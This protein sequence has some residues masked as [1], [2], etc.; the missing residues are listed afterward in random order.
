M[1]KI[2]T[3]LLVLT[4]CVSCTSCSKDEGIGGTGRAGKKLPG[5]LYWFFAGKAGYYNLESGKVEKEWMSMG[6]A[7]SFFDAFDISWD[8]RK[9]LLTMDVEGSFNFDER[10]FVL[11]ENKGKITYKG[12]NDGQNLRDFNYEWGDIKTT[13]GHLS[14][15]EKYVAVEAQ[16]FSDLPLTILDMQT[17]DAISSWMVEGISF[18]RYGK[19]VW[20]ADNTLYFRIGNKLYKCS[21]SNGYRS[22]PKVLDLGQGDS[23]VTVNP[24]GTKLVFRRNRHLWMCDI[25][26]SNLKQITTSR[27]SKVIE[28]D[29]EHRPTFSPDGKYIAFTGDSSSGTAWSDHDYPDGSWVSATGG[30][31]GYIAIIPA[32]GKLYDLDDKKSGA[33]W[34]K[35]P[36]GAG[37]IACSDMLIWR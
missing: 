24:E 5:T 4:F 28:W 12:L 30:K 23:Y 15:D 3:M 31:F 11:R 16:H 32:D 36:T 13:Y 17:G 10:R 8:N 25:D 14:P 19:P 33:I 29:G 6:T 2:M 35:N 37:G 18:L 26:G 21:P 34:L 20:T 7:S 1:R 22:A 27:T 9:I